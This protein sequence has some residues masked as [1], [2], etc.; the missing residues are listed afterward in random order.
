MPGQSWRDTGHTSK[1]SKGLMPGVKFDEQA[2]QSEMRSELSTMMKLERA[3]T[4]TWRHHAWT[5][6]AS[7]VLLGVTP[8]YASVL[9]CRSTRATMMVED[10]SLRFELVVASKN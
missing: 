7:A 4:T 6:S 5:A 2:A 9:H 8:A 1:A 10:T 3:A